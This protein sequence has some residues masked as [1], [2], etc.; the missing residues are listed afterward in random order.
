MNPR[1]YKAYRNPRMYRHPKMFSLDLECKEIRDIY[2]GLE[3]EDPKSDSEV[4]RKMDL[5]RDLIRDLKCF[6]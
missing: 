5:Q 4:S 3:R 2:I 6:V 1:M